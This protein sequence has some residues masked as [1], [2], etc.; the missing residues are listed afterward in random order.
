M[1]VRKMVRPKT[2]EEIELEINP[3][4]CDTQQDV[5]VTAVF[6]AGYDELQFF[7]VS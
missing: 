6:P 3:S 4:G 1:I 7:D 5:T 2:E